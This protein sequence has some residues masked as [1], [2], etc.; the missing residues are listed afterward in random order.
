MTIHVFEENPLDRS[1]KTAL[2]IGGVALAVGAAVALWPKKA[3]ATALPSGDAPAQAKSGLDDAAQWQVVGNLQ[4]GGIYLIGSMPPPGA[5]VDRLT[6][7]SNLQHMGWTNGSVLYVPGE[8]LSL[9][10]K[11]LPQPSDPAVAKNMFVI[12]GTWGQRPTNLDQTSMQPLLWTG[13][14]TNRREP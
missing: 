2:W 8:D 6:L 12:V 5:Q 13:Q 11:A 1:T 14:G 7:A 3:K 4:P 9:W 10:P